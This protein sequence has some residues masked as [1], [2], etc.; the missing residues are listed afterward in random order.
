MNSIE[1]KFVE[2][3][4]NVC[5][6]LILLYLRYTIRRNDIISKERAQ[7]ILLTKY[8]IRLIIL[9]EIIEILC[10]D[11]D[12]TIFKVMF[13][14][15][16][17]LVFTF[18][19][20]IPIVLA[21]LFNKKII[22]KMKI[23]IW[24]IIIYIFTCLFS[25]YFYATNLFAK[26]SIRMNIPLSIFHLVITIYSYIIF[27]YCLNT[28]KQFGDKSEE[29]YLRKIALFI[30]FGYA[31]NYF[32][33]YIHTL[34]CCLA[35]SLLSYYVFLGEMERKYDSL[36]HFK[37]YQCFVT[38]MTE[39]KKWGNFTVIIIEVIRLSEINEKYGSLEGDKYIVD[40]ANIIKSVYHVTGDIYSLVS[41]KFCVILQNASDKLVQNT[42]VRLH[43]KTKKYG[44]K[45]FPLEFRVGYSS[46]LVSD[47]DTNLNECSYQLIHQCFFQ[48]EQQLYENRIAQGECYDAEKLQMMFSE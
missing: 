1:C 37:N 28:S 39:Q 26:T 38:H 25:V 6:L 4:P 33:P 15:A 18:S 2:I 47:T 44:M 19:P 35:L 40:A 5:A 41:G 8:C 17:I 27:I 16:R 21:I 22:E 30:A 46:C 45:E 20:V 3:V 9:F 48:A 31:F 32:N 13:I 10:R 7:S 36:T 24:P 29:R 42:L 34:W 14:L 12:S 11:V 23:L 43:V